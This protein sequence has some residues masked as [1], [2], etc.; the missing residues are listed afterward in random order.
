L[1]KLPSFFDP[2][3]TAGNRLLD[4]LADKVDTKTMDVVMNAVRTNADLLKVLENV[5]PSQRNRVIRALSNDKSWMPAATASVT[6]GGAIM[7][8]ED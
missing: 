4:I 2:K 6:A 1:F 3:V 5:P 8:G 7:A